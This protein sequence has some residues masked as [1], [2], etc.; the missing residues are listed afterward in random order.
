MI[1]DLD[2]GLDGLDIG[3][4]LVKLHRRLLAE[5]AGQTRSGKCR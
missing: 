5:L 3:D 4:R 2:I 1:P